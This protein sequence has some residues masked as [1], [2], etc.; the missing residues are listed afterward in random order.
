MFLANDTTLGLDLGSTGLRA[1]EAG[2]SG[3][4]P[5]IQRWA[6]LDFTEPV[7]DW[8][9]MDPDEMAGRI[10][11]AM[12]RGGLKGH[13]A[14]HAMGGE[15]VA[16]QYFNFPQILPEDVAEAV[17]MEVEAS[18]PFPAEGA[19]VSHLLF[20]E[21]R[22][23]PG[24]VRTHGLAIAAEG[25]FAESR[26]L[27]IRQAGLETFYLETD[28]TACANA[29][30][31][32]V[33]AR[34]RESSASANDPH[35]IEPVSGDDET[36]VPGA[37]RGHDTTAILNVGHRY[38]NLALLGPQGTLLVRDVPWAG[39]QI[40]KSIMSVLS[41]SADEAENMKRAHWE[42]GPSAAPELEKQLPAILESC[43]GECVG[44]LRDT[45]Q[46]WVGERLVPGLGRIELTGGGSQFRGLKVMLEEAFEVP[47]EHWTP[48][49]DFAGEHAEA[50]RREAPRLTVA[51][52]LALRELATRN[53]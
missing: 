35:F 24:K 29:Y 23:A 15:A 4:R 18:L 21:Q 17:R 47:V 45:V 38:T 43:A 49:L 48:A 22:L 26:L 53:R 9:A 7:A 28:S 27:A 12:Q 14:A 34:G 50:M 42:K 30:L 2:W 37:M 39:D 36:P 25:D 31:V 1:V 40:T 41:L 44:R 46:Y 5:C 10:R 52:G 8:R 33:L 19:L 13:W 51:F 3:G 6:S 20:P 32:S 16:P 11:A